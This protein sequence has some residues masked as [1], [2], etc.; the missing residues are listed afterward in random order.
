MA[1]FTGFICDRDGCNNTQEGTGKEGNEYPFNW[2]LVSIKTEQDVREGQKIY[3]SDACTAIL[4]AERAGLQFKGAR[5]G[6]S[7][8]GTI[9]SDEARQQ[10]RI[11]GMLRQHHK[12]SHDTN[13]NPECPAC[14]EATA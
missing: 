4:F 12:G 11:N 5:K 8:S 7:R 2:V 14:Q 6:T 1:R 13:V 3:C 9:Y 10:F